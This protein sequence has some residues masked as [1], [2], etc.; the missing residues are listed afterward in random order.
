[1][2]SSAAAQIEADAGDSIKLPNGT[3]DYATI[4][5]ILIGAV[6]AWMIVCVFLG[7]E[8]DG[9]H[10]EQAHVAYQDGAGEVTH[11]ELVDPMRV[12]KPGEV[13][14]IEHKETVEKGHTMA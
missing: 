6:I 9:A 7:P 11:K 2:A 1:M 10:F 3:P 5:G 12:T 13:G 14:T 4:L 8:A